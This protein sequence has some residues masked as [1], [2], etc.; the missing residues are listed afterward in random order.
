MYASFFGLRELPFNNTPD[1]R[2][3]Y[4]TPDHEEALASL[5]YA[6]SER[7]GFVLLTGEVG[8]GKTLVSRMMLRHFGTQIAFAAIHHAIHSADELMEAVCGELELEVEP[9]ATRTQLVRQLH[10]LLL[11]RFARNIPVVLVLDEAQGL[12]VEAFEQVRMIGNLEEENAKLLQV[13][14]VGQ[15]E[16]KR[17]FGSQAMLQLRQRLFRSFHL[18]AMS[19]ADTEGYIRHRLIVAGA[20]EREIFDAGAL[21]AVYRMSR[22]LPRIINSI[23]DNAML[24]A[25]S[26]DRHVI[27]AALIESMEAPRSRIDES[28][29][30]P[31]EPNRS[32]ALSPSQ[33]DRTIEAPDSL[34]VRRQIPARSSPTSPRSTNVC[35]PATP[36]HTDAVLSAV[37]RAVD[38]RARHVG[39]KVEEAVRRLAVLETRFDRPSTKLIATQ[40]GAAG[41]RQGVDSLAT[42]SDRTPGG[43]VEPLVTRLRNI[44]D[45]ARGVLA[46]LAMVEGGADGALCAADARPIRRSNGIAHPRT[47]V[48]L[49]GGR[50]NPDH[51]REAL[52]STRQSLADL[53]TL[54]GRQKT[55][56]G[57]TSRR[58]TGLARSSPASAPA[59]N[60]TCDRV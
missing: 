52:E 2:F 18:P 27:D 47:A 41:S 19:R 35:R 30:Q 34:P 10:D 31:G 26:A 25:Y 23:C 44:V 59:N 39:L 51:W 21:N 56:I 13:V 12:P 53:R 43:R 9:K 48:G 36:Q 58:Q 11:S 28:A 6:V 17:R 37:R 57:S 49:L 32:V 3:F 24:T 60:L 46:G 50:R 42:V 45:E 4:P 55:P 14:I 1:P 16:L 15:P 22:G 8:A 7:K 33:S 20:G 5:V 40:D 38:N 29:V 54:A